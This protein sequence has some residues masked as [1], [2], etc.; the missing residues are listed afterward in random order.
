MAEQ[1]EDDRA[2][3]RVC[4]TGGTGFIASHIV[5]QL[6]EAGVAV[7]ATV[8]S[9]KSPNVAFL[10]ELAERTGGTLELFEASLE[11]A[12]SYDSAVQN[13]DTVIH[14]ACPVV[15]NPADPVKE[16]I[17]PSV[18][19]T[20]NVL[21]SVL[22]E[23]Q[24]QY[25]RNQQGDGAFAAMRVVMTSSDAA[26]YPSGAK[27]CDRVL[28]E[29]DWNTTADVH[30]PYP[31]AKK[32]A[33]EAAWTFMESDEAAEVGLSM[34][35]CNPSLVV[36]P[37]LGRRVPA[38]CSL[39]CDLLV[40]TLP[41]S[42][43]LNWPIVDVRDVASAHIAAAARRA[44]SGR[45]I[46]TSAD[47]MY[48]GDMADALHEAF[49]QEPVPLRKFPALVLYAI[50]LFDSRI[51]LS[52]ARLHA[53]RIF[54]FSNERA[55]KELGVTFRGAKQSI[56]DCGKALLDSGLVRERRE[57]L[58]KKNKVWKGR[59]VLAA[60]VSIAVLGLL[61]WKRRSLF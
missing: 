18:Q 53:N 22:K 58:A 41:G 48:V 47:N 59:A 29:A 40:P 32:L 38:S 28:T 5:L 6:L 26:I 61:W 57:A 49:P 19:G 20:L 27:S 35:V 39:V 1:L 60:S 51:S 36:G 55:K 46:L 9:K 11:K 14:T 25:R 24:H 50:A 23:A 17:T 42:V 4:V 10:L 15:Q 3:R 21:A 56:Q 16:L 12:N 37:P 52:W 44:A 30:S 31:L 2:L 43:P 8:R 13:C 45:Y 34:A 7:H 33:E 54:F